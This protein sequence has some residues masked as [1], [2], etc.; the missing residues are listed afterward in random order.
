MKPIPVNNKYLIS[1][2]RPHLWITSALA[3]I[4]VISLLFWLVFDY[5]RKSRRQK[6]L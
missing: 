3:L 6:M 5:G 4:L 2:Q 1:V